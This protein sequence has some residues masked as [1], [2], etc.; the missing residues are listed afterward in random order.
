MLDK[1]SEDPDDMGVAER[2][3]ELD[4]RNTIRPEWALIQEEVRLEKE[5]GSGLLGGTRLPL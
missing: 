2:L 5:I 3:V 4:L 1:R